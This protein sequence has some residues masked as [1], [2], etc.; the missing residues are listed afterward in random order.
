MVQSKLENITG[1]W[2]KLLI[3]S[4][5]RIVEIWG[6]LARDEKGGEI[7]YVDERGKVR[8]ERF[9]NRKIVSWQPHG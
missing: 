6:K 3:V 1:T 5:D 9:L 8:K 7:V 2:G 4:I